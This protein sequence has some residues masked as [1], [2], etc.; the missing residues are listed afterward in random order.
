MRA[1]YS[2]TSKLLCS[3]L[4]TFFFLTTR[5]AGKHSGFSPTGCSSSFFRIS[6]ISLS[7]PGTVAGSSL[8]RNN[9]VSRMPR[10]RSPI[11]NFKCRVRECKRRTAAFPAALI[12]RLKS[13]LRTVPPL[14]NCQ[15]NFRG[16][17]GRGFSLSR[18]MKVKL[19]S[20]R[21]LRLLACGQAL[22]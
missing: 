16:V 14:T 13:R 3:I 22:S 15:S 6:M 18:G 4:L 11:G 12:G 7:V 21:V 5:N 20:A 10:C 9:A 17:F 19:N 2:V 1:N 8:K